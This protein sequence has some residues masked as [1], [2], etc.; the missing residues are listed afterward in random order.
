MQA[1]RKL[2]SYPGILITV[3]LT[4]ALFLVGFCGWVAVTSKELIRYV[5]QNI[6][7]Q[8]Y[9]DK[10]LSKESI[11]LLE[12]A[13]K[14]KP[15]YDK[16]HAVRFISKDEAAQIFFKETNED[17]KNVLPENP[18]RDAFSIKIKDTYFGENHLKEIKS[19]LEK[20]SGVYEADYPHDFV[21]GISQNAN[22][23]Y[24]IVSGIVII[25]LLAT[26]LLINNT[27]RLAL[28]SQRFIIRTMQLV[29]ATD[30]FIQKPFLQ[31]GA[32]QGLLSGCIAALLLVIFQQVSV[33]QISGFETVQDYTSLYFLV[34]LLLILGI[35]LGVLSTFASVSRYLRLDLDELY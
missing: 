5:K 11:S 3:S 6:E 1:N 30:A 33:Q 21:D 32:W 12:K 34:G 9:L 24:I 15:Y 26:L 8:A 13:I 29:G 2:G 23:V 18:L 25:F 16:N 7:I 19:D 35:L 14:T 31:R 22:R 28:Y 10:D 17:Y 4:V 27:I 20:L